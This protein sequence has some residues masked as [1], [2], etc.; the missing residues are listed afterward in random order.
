MLKSTHTP[1]RVRD[2]LCALNRTG[3]S[4]GTHSVFR[5]ALSKRSY[6]IRAAPRMR[7]VLLNRQSGACSA[8]HIVVSRITPACDVWKGEDEEGMSKGEKHVGE[9]GTT[10]MGRGVQPVEGGTA[11]EVVD[12]RRGDGES[13]ER[14]GERGG[15]PILCPWGWGSRRRTIS[16]ATQAP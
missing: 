16:G 10:R 5:A 15:A 1:M 7:A 8:P 2:A 9:E 13:V 3:W 11:A 6:A 4:A 12:G 14:K